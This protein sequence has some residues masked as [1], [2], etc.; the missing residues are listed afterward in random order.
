MPG[1]P[2]PIPT[3][4]LTKTEERMWAL[5]RGG[6]PR[7]K[8]ELHQCL[9]EDMAPMNGSAVANHIRHLRE[10]IGPSCDI[11]SYPRL[12]TFWYRLVAV[13]TENDGDDS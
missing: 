6:E 11:V 10:K 7:T 8:E 9:W 4:A 1:V 5:L 13:I 12:G 3:T 2:A